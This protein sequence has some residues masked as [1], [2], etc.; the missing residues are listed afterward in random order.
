MLF[1]SHT[2]SSSFLR[3]LTDEKHISSAFQSCANVNESKTTS[4][5]KERWR[6]VGLVGLLR[7]FFVHHFFALFVSELVVEVEVEEEEASPSPSASSSSPWKKV[8][9]A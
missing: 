8:K 6:L 1:D 3:P 5:K 4:M 2:G 7:W 9:R